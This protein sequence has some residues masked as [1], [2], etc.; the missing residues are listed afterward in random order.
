MRQW[1]NRLRA[2]DVDVLLQDELN[3][4][5]LFGVNRR[6]RGRVR[7]PIVSI[8]HHLRSSE[9][10]PPLLRRLYRQVESLYLNSVDAFIYNSHTTR[11]S[12]RRP[13]AATPAAHRGLPGGRPPPRGSADLPGNRH[14][15]RHMRRIRSA[16]CSWAT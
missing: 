14:P 2:A 8:V 16:S 3:H 12:R 1:S 5:S 11:A 6:L 4:P 15:T 10:H 7:Y 13:P 9:E